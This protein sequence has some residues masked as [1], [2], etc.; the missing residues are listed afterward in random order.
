MTTQIFTARHI[1]AGLLAVVVAV[2]MTLLL[3]ACAPGQ[4]PFAPPTAPAPSEPP[5]EATGDGWQT[6]APLPTARSEM[7]VAVVDGIFYLPGGF[8]GLEK[9]EAYD[10]ASDS[11]ASLAPLPEPVHHQMVAAFGG[12]VYVLGGARNLTWQATASV[13]VYDPARDEWTTADPMPERRISGEAVAL[14]DFIY[15]VGG[16]NGT[17]SLLR[18]DPAAEEWQV[19]PGPSQPREHVAAVAY[20]GELWVIGGRWQNTG[21][22]ASVE[23]FDPATGAWRDGPPLQEARSGFGAAV[24]SGPAGEW[25]VVAGGEILGPRPWTALASAEVYDPARGEWERL[26][27]LPAGI[28]GMPLAAHDGA[29][30]VLGG[31]DQAGG[32]DNRG[33]VLRLPIPAPQTASGSP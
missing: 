19:L 28:H 30:Y 17:T 32:I 4:F 9:L 13:F 12:K 15:V 1:R 16:T 18:F 25:I 20:D 29:V 10:P 31:S 22:L 26:P 7:R 3:A 27:D 24:V 6:G 21:A 5:S 23:I 14:G 11:W 8:G 33:R 2:A